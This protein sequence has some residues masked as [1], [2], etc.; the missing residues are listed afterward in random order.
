MLNSGHTLEWSGPTVEATRR[1]GKRVFAQ[2]FKSWLVERAKQPGV[3]VAGLALSHGINANQLRRWMK[4]ADQDAGA[5]GALLPVCI[6]QP[7][8]IAVASA[9][10]LAAP[11]HEKDLIE[12]EIG[13][14]RVKLH[15]RVDADQ[16]RAVLAA[17][18][19]HA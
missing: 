17:L 1:D 14:A 5:A 12:V 6:E 10:R 9:R 19:A 2:A 15:G 18:A 13:A 4:L 3:S 8:A 7:G 11:V 16:L